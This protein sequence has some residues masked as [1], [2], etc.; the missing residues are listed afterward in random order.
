MGD[1][2]CSALATADEPRGVLPFGPSET[3]DGGEQPEKPPQI[4][5]L[6][7]G[8]FCRDGS[9]PH[10]YNDAVAHAFV[11][12]ANRAIFPSCHGARA[13]GWSTVNSSWIWFFDARSGELIGHEE[14]S[15]W[16]E[17]VWHGRG[18]NL[19]GCK[20]HGDEPDAGHPVRSCEGARAEARQQL[21][22]ARIDGCYG[23]R[24]DDDAGATEFEVGGCELVLT[25]SCAPRDGGAICSDRD[26]GTRFDA[27]CAAAV[28][29]GR[30][31]LRCPQMLR[32]CSRPPIFA[33]AIRLTP[34]PVIV[35]GCDRTKAYD[36][37]PSGAV[38]SIYGYRCTKS[39][40]TDH[41]IRSGM[42]P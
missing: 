13:V 14:L 28:E 17:V 33:S 5:R 10:D 8:P 42:G 1:G 24:T 16:G 30:R 15:F 6:P 41:E 32:T 34:L 38:G 12:K 39:V 3:D 29:Q 20:S 21:N 11:G 23:R 37:R 40:W 9:C 36:C 25:Y 2:G 19:E 22:C 7:L 18:V 31:D 27:A 4:V 35:N 26:G